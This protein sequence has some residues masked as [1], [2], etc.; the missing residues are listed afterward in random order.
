MS[1]T[2]FVPEI[3]SAQLLSSLKNTEVAAGLCNRE[4]EGEIAQKGDTVHITSI[5]RP[6]IAEYVKDTTVIAPETLTDADQTLLIDQSYYF[7]FEVDDI[8]KRQ[9]VNGGALM[10]EAAQEAAYGFADKT[11]LYLWALM[12]AGVSQAAPD[13]LIEAHTV[14]ADK[15]AVNSLMAMKTA[16]DTTNVPKQGR[17]VAIP[18]WFEGLCLLDSRFVV[19]DG[20]SGGGAYRNGQIGRVMGFDVVLSNNLTTSDGGNDS[21]LIAGHSMATSFAEQINKVEAYRPQGSFSDA[22]KGL[23]LYGAKVVRPEAIV[24]SI[25]SQT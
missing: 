13:N 2:H 8:D 21:A 12:E 16:L 11:D 25:C 6:T 10:T 3:W 15:L 23:H 9:A 4:Y 19:I 20:F 7:A 1:I 22:L 14:A 5:G 17:W 24:V 18:P